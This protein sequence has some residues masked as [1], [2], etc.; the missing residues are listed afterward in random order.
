MIERFLCQTKGEL[1]MHKL[2]FLIVAAAL[3]S[4]CSPAALAG[5]ATPMIQQT[6]KASVIAQVKSSGG[7]EAQ[8]TCAAD[9]VTQTLK[10]EDYAAAAASN[11]SSPRI[12]QVIT[13]SIKACTAK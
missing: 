2:S 7:T 6:V 1:S 12:N 9:K 5:L 3:T 8:A 11:G 10:A 13:E 4:A